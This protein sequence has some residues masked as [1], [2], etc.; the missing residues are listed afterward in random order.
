LLRELHVLARQGATQGWATAPQ[1]WSLSELI[2]VADDRAEVTSRLDQVMRTSALL[3]RKRSSWRGKIVAAVAGCVLLGV[4]LA[5]LTR[6]PSLLAGATSGPPRQSSAWAQLYQAK[7]VDTAAAWQ[8][9]PE[10]FPNAD[11][12]L[13]DLALQGLANFYLFQSQEWDKAIEP[14]E[15][16]AG[17]GDLYPELKAFGIAGLVV[18]EANLGD[19]EKA[20]NENSRLDSPMRTLLEDRSP[21]LYEALQTTLENLQ[22]GGG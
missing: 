12:H 8:A 21:R 9:V 3:T 6:P 1:D 14:L 22:Q 18:A 19:T 2:A 10:L 20:R 7:T 5:L 17:L 16:L 13:H 4:A 11:H 15:H